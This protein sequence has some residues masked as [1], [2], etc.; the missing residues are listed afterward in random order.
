[1]PHK[2]VIILVIL[3][4]AAAIGFWIYRSRTYHF[5]EVAKGVLYRD[6]LRNANEFANA[7]RNGRIRC[8][9][10]LVSDPEI[11]SPRFAPAISACQS[12]GIRTLRIPVALGGWP[13]TADLHQFFTLVS[14]SSNQP[15]LVHCREGVRRTGM[16][17]AA[18]QMSVL[19]WSKQQT[20][21]AIVTFGH[22]R[23]SIGDIE[24]FIDLYDPA[25]RS[26]TYPTTMPR[27]DE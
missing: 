7:C 22:S 16:M 10:S 3:V 18:Y 6:G 21:A 24:H 4:V 19:G 9:I 25:A 15:A 1:M 17:V 5:R 26:I 12:R 27:G 14:D 8:V 11:T 13:T 2:A 23:R 20:K